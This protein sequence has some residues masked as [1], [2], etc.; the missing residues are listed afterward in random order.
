MSHQHPPAGWYP[1]PGA[2]GTERYWDGGAWTADERT[3]PAAA[4]HSRGSAPARGTC[5]W[6]GW[7]GLQQRELM[8]NT[9]GMTFMGWDWANKGAQCLVC[10]RCGYI[11]WFAP[12]PNKR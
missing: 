4:A 3:A 12:L 10:E 11:H 8:M 1:A 2:R 7:T 5:L 6:C 9:R